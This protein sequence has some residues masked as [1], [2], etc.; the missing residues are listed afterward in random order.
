VP[1]NLV[2]HKSVKSLNIISV[3]S[4]VLN[5]LYAE[6]RI[7]NLHPDTCGDLVRAWLLTEIF[8]DGF[9]FCIEIIPK[10]V[11]LEHELTFTLAYRDLNIDPRPS[12]LPL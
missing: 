10:I 8:V 7:V 11:A 1:S 6:S 9:I 12:R 5:G 4:I 2:C 3:E